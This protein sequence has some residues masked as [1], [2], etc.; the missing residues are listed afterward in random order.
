MTTI[1]RTEGG[2]RARLQVFECEGHG[3]YFEVYEAGKYAG[4]Y[5]GS[6][7]ALVIPTAP[8]RHPSCTLGSVYGGRVAEV[9]GYKAYEA[10][11]DVVMQA[12]P[13]GWDVSDVVPVPVL[14]LVREVA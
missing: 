6:D 11:C 4:T 12:D 3:R 1:G 2:F 14:A 9:Y 5:D 13:D 10:A 8:Y 7:G